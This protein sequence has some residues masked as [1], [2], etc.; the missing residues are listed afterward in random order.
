MA[1]EFVA[2]IDI[3]ARPR[4]R[5]LLLCH[6]CGRKLSASHGKATPSPTKNARSSLLQ[7]CK[8]RRVRFLLGESPRALFAFFHDELVQRGIDG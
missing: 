1:F 6:F 8:Q 3:N 4:V 2:K 5:L 7:I